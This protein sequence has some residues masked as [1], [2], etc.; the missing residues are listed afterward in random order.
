MYKLFKAVS[1]M[2]KGLKYK[3]ILAFSLMSIMPLLLCGVLINKY[4]YEQ[5]IIIGDTSLLVLITTII[6]LLGLFVAKS[7]VDPVIQISK[8]LKLYTDGND[9]GQIP[10][11][12]E[13]EIGDL[14]IS[15]NSMASK[16]NKN[17]DTLKGYEEQIRSIN[18]D[19][20]KKMT[21]LSTLFQ[22]SSIMSGAG[23]LSVILQTVIE[24]LPDVVDCEKSFLVIF[25]AEGA[26]VKI[27]ATNN[28]K[29]EEMEALEKDFSEGVL[30]RLSK[31]RESLV[32]DKKHRVDGATK[33]LK[34]SLNL[35]NIIV[36]PV[37]LHGEVKCDMI[38]GNNKND[39][40]FASDD[41]ELMKVFSKQISIA[42]ENNLLMNK[43]KELSVRDEL[44]GLYNIKYLRERLNEEIQRA[45][46]YQRPC[47]FILVEVDNFDACQDRFGKQVSDEI[48][49]KIASIIK[50]N[51]ERIDKVGRFEQCAFALILPEKNK[52]EAHMTADKIR[53][54]IE[55]FDFANQESMPEKNITVSAAVTAN[56]LD[57]MS[58]EE[59][60]IKARKLL[61]RA[62]S[63]DANKVYT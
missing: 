29:P 3:L 48:L 22:V 58:S 32:L 42:I 15:I 14:S 28:L 1:L 59:L 5:D 60:V 41:L 12:R 2:P 19:I 49:K 13:D 7:I 50:A 56:P 18:L 27:K 20:N 10:T 17:V 51:V 25:E 4:V 36:F 31:Q 11:N 33:S 45:I 44:T 8:K 6:A 57:G 46:T 53:E 21:A 62:R 9:L 24:R 43:T 23:D 47:S 26:G 35:N 38:L 52:K 61:D 39:F 55:N 54:K 37:V 34:K 16:I 63:Q 30:A 40:S